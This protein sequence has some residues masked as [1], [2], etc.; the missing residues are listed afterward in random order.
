MGGLS[1][2]PA[3]SYALQTIA[4]YI[5][6]LF[7]GGVMILLLGAWWEHLRRN[8]FRRPEGR[9]ASSS[10]AFAQRFVFEEE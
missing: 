2:H 3:H 8:S 9:R 4:F 6:M 7:P 1:E 5:S 10:A